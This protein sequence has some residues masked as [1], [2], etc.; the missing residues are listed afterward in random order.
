MT[1]RVSDRNP[2]RA[3]S[4][5][6]AREDLRQQGSDRGRNAKI[7]RGV[8]SMSPGQIAEHRHRCA[9]SRTRSRPPVPR[10]M[11]RRFRQR[12]RRVVRHRVAEDGLRN[13]LDREVQERGERA[14]AINAARGTVRAGFADFAARHERDLD[15]DEREEKQD[16]GL[17]DRGR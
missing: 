7:A 13:R 16:R 12:R 17:P 1:L 3:K 5:V 2:R 8:Q 15:A 10:E 9:A 14:S 4:R 6:N 11:R